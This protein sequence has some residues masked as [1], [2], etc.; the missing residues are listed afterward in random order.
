[1]SNT[2]NALKIQTLSIV[3]PFEQ[4]PKYRWTRFWT[5]WINDIQL[6]AGSNGSKS[7][8][9][10]YVYIRPHMF[11]RFSRF[12]SWIQQ[13]T[14][15]TKRNQ[16]A[17]RTQGTGWTCRSS[18][19]Q[20]KSSGPRKWENRGGSNSNYWS[21]ELSSMNKL[22]SW[23]HTI[24]ARSHGGGGDILGPCP[25]PPPLELSAP[26]P[27]KIRKYSNSCHVRILFSSI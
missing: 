21:S 15:Q 1:M 6:I 8:S 19:S 2:T 7:P 18:G 5:S 14:E 26:P 16:A 4:H 12:G 27:L 3:L 20:Q 23:F 9:F 17:N 10:L 11:S 25:P 13:I 22:L 24:Q